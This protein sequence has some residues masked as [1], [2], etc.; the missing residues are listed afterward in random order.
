MTP[1]IFIAL[2]ALFAAFSASAQEAPK[3]LLLKLVDT[4]A[5][6]DET[7]TINGLLATEL[8]KFDHFALLSGTDLEAF[9]NIENERHMAGCDQTS[10][11]V[12]LA[13]AMGTRFVIYGEA[14]RL[15]SLIV[16]NLSLLDS[17]ASEN[18]SRVSLEAKSLEQVPAAL[19]TGLHPLT[20]PLNTDIK[21]TAPT[22]LPKDNTAVAPPASE[23]SST[24]YVIAGVGAGVALAGIAMAVPPIWVRTQID[25][26]ESDYRAGDGDAL[27]SASDIQ[28]LWYDGFPLADTLL[29]GGI[30][31]AVTGSAI[32]TT[33]LA[34]GLLGE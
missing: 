17:D 22:E 15:G 26:L 24:P 31:L 34:L 30:A 3:V 16:L 5:G 19:R 9:A 8:Q 7:R 25:G 11:L 6:P 4:G 18:L 32:A 21:T 27:K 14:G 12:E 10:C 1:R 33:G 13:Q 2:F 28:A 23:S 20:D 29:F